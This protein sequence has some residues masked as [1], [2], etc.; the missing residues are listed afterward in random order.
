VVARLSQYQTGVAAITTN[1][2]VVVG[3]PQQTF[4][5]LSYASGVWSA[6]GL[7]VSGWTDETLNPS[8]VVALDAN[9]VAFSS[10]VFDPVQQKVLF[11]VWLL[12]RGGQNWSAAVVATLPSTVQSISAMSAI[13][14]NTLILPGGTSTDRQV[15]RVVKSNGIWTVQSIATGGAL[16]TNDTAGVC[17]V[18]TGTG[19]AEVFI[20]NR[21]G[22]L[23]RMPMTLA[24]SWTP[25]SAPAVVPL[26]M[27]PANASGGAAIACTASD[28]GH[29]YLIDE[30]LAT[31]YD[32]LGSANWTSV[33]INASY[34]VPTQRVNVPG[35]LASMRFSDPISLAVVP[36]ASGLELAVIDAVEPTLLYLKLR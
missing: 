14:A 29:V 12:S 7:P 4:T 11:H 35:P 28:P 25:S 20:S 6:T 27:L 9:T 36:G 24:S 26:P 2:I 21:S 22:Q 16:A 33:S 8:A 15:W 32:F 3:S 17:A 18:L 19:T 23:L 1:E 34:G 10:K 13:D 30:G 5:L 31:L